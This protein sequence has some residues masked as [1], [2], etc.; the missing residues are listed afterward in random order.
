MRVGLQNTKL[1]FFFKI[2]KL[3]LQN[4]PT[5]E[6]ILPLSYENRLLFFPSLSFFHNFLFKF[7]GETPI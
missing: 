3:L 1:S 7:W 2:A 5:I 6:K 4:L